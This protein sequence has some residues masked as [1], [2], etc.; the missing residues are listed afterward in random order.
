MARWGTTRRAGALLTAGAMVLLGLTAAASAHA[1][2]RARTTG[3]GT[4]QLTRCHL[5]A[6]R[7]TWCGSL[8]VPL[9]YTDPAAPRIKVGFGWLPSRRRSVGTLVAMEGGPGYPST[10]TAGDF[11]AMYGGLLRDHDL[12]LVDA[13]KRTHERTT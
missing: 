8:R 2:P 7:P 3:I 12:L 4:T 9:D 11:A 10:G 13:M 5:G 6:G 1:S